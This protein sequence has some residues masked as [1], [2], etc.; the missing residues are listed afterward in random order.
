M[1]TEQNWETFTVEVILMSSKHQRT[2]QFRL[3]AE[4]IQSMQLL[5]YHN[6]KV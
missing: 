6:E 3:D 5:S 4:D 2:L 1:L